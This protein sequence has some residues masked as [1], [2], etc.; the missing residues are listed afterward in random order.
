MMFTDEFTFTSMQLASIFYTML[1]FFG[2]LI[3][4][5]DDDDDHD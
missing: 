4:T 5:H 3:N 2:S 1:C